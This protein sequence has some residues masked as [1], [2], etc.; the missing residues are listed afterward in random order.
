MAMPAVPNVVVPR[1]NEVGLTEMGPLPPVP[2]VTMPSNGP[3]VLVV[4]SVGVNKIGSTATTTCNTAVSPNDVTVT[5]SYTY[6]FI[7]PLGNFLNSLAGGIPPM[8]SS[9]TMRVE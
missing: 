1:S 7:T 6:P 5:A 3:G 2:I 9:A 4:L 8:T